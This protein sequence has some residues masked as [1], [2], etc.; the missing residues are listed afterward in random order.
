MFANGPRV[1]FGGKIE[2][3]VQMFAIGLRVRF[4][5]E[6]EMEWDAQSC[7]RGREIAPP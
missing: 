7:K 3:I 4:G 2:M 5:G 1:R 6:I